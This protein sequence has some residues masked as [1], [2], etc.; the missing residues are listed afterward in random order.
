MMPFAGIIYLMLLVLLIL[1]VAALMILI[2]NSGF[3]SELMLRKKPELPPMSPAQG[4]ASLRD[5][6]KYGTSLLVLGGD[7]KEPHDFIKESFD[8]SYHEIIFSRTEQRFL[9]E[10]FSFR[11]NITF[12]WVTHRQEGDFQISVS[13]ISKMFWNIKQV[14]INLR[15]TIIFID[16]LEYLVFINGFSPVARMLNEVIDLI[17]NL[18]IILVVW[19]EPGAF[20][21]K[22]LTLLER[23]VT[24]VH[25]GRGQISHG[26]EREEDTLH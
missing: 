25:E 22:E 21:E 24:L 9:K 3:R 19:T 12:F 20:E 4:L 15:K 7:M 6:I 10:K 13:D 5:K 11:K 18:D 8:E 14:S 1:V 17:A 23:S 2:L 26:R 16:C